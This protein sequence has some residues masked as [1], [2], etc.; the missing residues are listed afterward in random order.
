[1][2]IWSVPQ[3]TFRRR[4]YN[5]FIGGEAFDWV[6]L[7][8][9]MF[10]EVGKLI[11]VPEQELL[12]FHSRLPKLVT[13]SDIQTTLGV[14]KYRGYLNYLYGVTV[15]EALQLAVEL[16]IQKE[17]TS[18]GAVFKENF[19]DEIFSHIYH[20]SRAELHDLFLNETGY[21][22]LKRLSMT[23][24]KEFTYWLAKYRWQNS[25]GARVASDT[26][27]GLKQLQL[28]ERAWQHTRKKVPLN[29]S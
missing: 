5:Y 17:H 27:K 25:D 7:A 20:K 16:E 3:E 28:M 6:L 24:H 1:M 23:E 15:E 10:A 9:R 12:I 19:S 26:N 22:K 29:S 13:E 8:E 21:R 2:Q 11:P 4:K 14:P 18:R